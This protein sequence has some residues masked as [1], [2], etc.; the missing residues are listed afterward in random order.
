[1]VV[2]KV[3]LRLF[4]AYLLCQVLVGVEMG[5]VM[6]YGMV[7]FGWSPTTAAGVLPFGLV[8]LVIQYPLIAYLLA[9][10]SRA[11]NGGK[12]QAS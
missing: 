4:G 1:M 12:K 7:Q 11:A 8:L 2:L 9:R 3:I 6:A 5:V 10:L